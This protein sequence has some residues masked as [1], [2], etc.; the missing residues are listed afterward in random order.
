MV[1]QLVVDL[2]VQLWQNTERSLLNPGIVI[3]KVGWTSMSSTPTG[4]P[5]SFDDYPVAIWGGFT[6]EDYTL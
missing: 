5:F 6:V 4:S 3:D 2:M 1:Q